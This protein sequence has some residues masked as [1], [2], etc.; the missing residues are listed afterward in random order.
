M[1]LSFVTFEIPMHIFNNYT[2]FGSII[3][4]YNKGNL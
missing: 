2:P 1:Q 3:I 4:E